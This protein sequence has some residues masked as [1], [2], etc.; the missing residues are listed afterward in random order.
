MPQLRRHFRWTSE[1]FKPCKAFLK[2]D[3]AQASGL[4]SNS[5]PIAVEPF[6]ARSPTKMPCQR[7][8]RPTE[9]PDNPAQGGQLACLACSTFKRGTS[10][11]NVSFRPR[12]LASRLTVLDRPITA[13][14]R[15]CSVYGLNRPD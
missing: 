6:E 13:T 14:G 11:G 2:S 1:N 8:I 7:R 10:C 15:M 5:L 3:A 4:L 9:L 12:R